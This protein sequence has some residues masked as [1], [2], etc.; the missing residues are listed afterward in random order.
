MNGMYILSAE[1]EMAIIKIEPLNR[2][3]KKAFRALKALPKKDRKDIASYW[4]RKE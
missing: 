1:S 2:L 4:L 3:R